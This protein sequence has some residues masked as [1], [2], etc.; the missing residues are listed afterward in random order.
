MTLSQFII[1]FFLAFIVLG[2]ISVLRKEAN[3]VD[4][5]FFGIFGGFSGGFMWVLIT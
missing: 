5:F 3:W 1:C 4:L 2:S